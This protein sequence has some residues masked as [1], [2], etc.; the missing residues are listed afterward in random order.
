[1]VLML[2]GRLVVLLVLFLGGRDDVVD[3]DHV[4]GAVIEGSR[5]R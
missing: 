3:G 5:R 4:S 2:K 1:M